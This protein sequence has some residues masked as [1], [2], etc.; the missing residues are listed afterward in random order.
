VTIITEKAVLAKSKRVHAKIV[1]FGGLADGEGLPEVSLDT[2]LLLALL[3]SIIEPSSGFH[4][5]F[6]LL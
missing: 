3:C 4:Q 6:S 1:D 5:L 2:G